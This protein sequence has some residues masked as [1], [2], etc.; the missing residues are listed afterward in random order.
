MI[1]FPRNKSPQPC[2]VFSLYISHI[3]TPGHVY[4]S[5]FLHVR[6]TG[7]PEN[8]VDRQFFVALVPLILPHVFHCC[9]HV[10]LAKQ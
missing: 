7:A 6:V 2:A 1:V 9:L 4:S 3:V 5:L 8:S 10:D